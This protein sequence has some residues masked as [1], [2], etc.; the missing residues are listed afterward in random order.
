MECALLIATRLALAE[1][2]IEI[3]IVAVKPSPS[4]PISAE[5]IFYQFPQT[6]GFGQNAIHDYEQF[7]GTVG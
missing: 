2:A 6:V 1:T 4:T 7:S 3:I 5:V